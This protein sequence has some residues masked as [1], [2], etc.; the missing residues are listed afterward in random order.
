MYL[1]TQVRNQENISINKYIS[2]VRVCLLPIIIYN[3]KYCLIGQYQ[4]IED[5]IPSDQIIII[6]KQGYINSKLTFLQL[7][8]IFKL[9]I[10]PTSTSKS[11]VFSLIAILVIFPTIQP[12]SYVKY[13]FTLPTYLFY[14]PYIITYYRYFLYV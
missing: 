2:T 8:D 13:Y 11:I 9:A 14:L 10:H 6:L 1:I 5:T 4:K 3:R 12:L 7:K